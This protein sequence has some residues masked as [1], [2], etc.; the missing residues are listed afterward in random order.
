[1]KVATDA[2]LFGAWASEEILKL[3]IIGRMLDIG[4]GTGLLSLMIL[5]KNPGL[6]IDAIEIDPGAA[7]QANSNTT[8]SLFEPKINV[9]HHDA[10]NYYYTHLYDLIVT[11]PLL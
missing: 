1:M 3:R 4:T 8:N 10:L 2:C 11:N 6:L 5:Q 9:I 7:E